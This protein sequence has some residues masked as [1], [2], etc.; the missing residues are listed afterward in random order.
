MHAS[1]TVDNR[2]LRSFGLIF[3]ALLLLIFAGLF[4]WIA[5][6]SIPYWP[7]W[8]AAPVAALALVW[9]RGLK[10]LYIV[11]MKFG[12]VMGRI[13]TFLILSILFYAMVTPI[14]WLMR[15]TGKD[16]MRRKLDRDSDSYRI[17]SEAQSRDHMEKPY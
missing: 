10:P 7:F 13:N 5:E 12:E 15:L 17:S 14:G 1:P 11:W 4:P 3:A 16:P 9:P 2:Q 8:I 6:R